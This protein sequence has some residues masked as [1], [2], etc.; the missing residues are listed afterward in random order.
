MLK[1]TS[2]VQRHGTMTRTSVPPHLFGPELRQS[3]E[4][5]LKG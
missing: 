2:V 1:L 5:D 3:R 4:Q